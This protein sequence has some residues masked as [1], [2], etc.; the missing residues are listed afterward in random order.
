[1]FAFSHGDIINMPERR[2]NVNLYINIRDFG[3]DMAISLPFGHDC[4]HCMP[5]WTET[6]VALATDRSKWFF[7]N[8]GINIPER[9][10]VN[11]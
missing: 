9:T 6:I 11:L 2:T 3:R 5:T 8:G 10:A 7:F 4:L 1:M